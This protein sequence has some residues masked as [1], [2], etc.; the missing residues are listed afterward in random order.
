MFSDAASS[1]RGWYHLRDNGHE[2]RIF[3]ASS[4]E[5]IL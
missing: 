5:E 1:V 3:D 2:E 4:F